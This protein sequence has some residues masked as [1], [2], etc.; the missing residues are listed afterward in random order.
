L[1][2]AAGN[3]AA[4]IAVQPL[5]NFHG[6]GHLNHSLFWENLSPASKDGGAPPTGELAKAIDE[7]FGGVDAF[8]TKMN[9]ALAGIQG[10]GWGWL[11]KDK[12]SGKLEL[13]TKPVC[14]DRT[15]HIK[16]CCELIEYLRIKIL[17]WVNMSHCWESM[18][19]NMRTSKLN[20]Y[21]Q[22]YQMWR[23]SNKNFT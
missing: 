8:K 9:A 6:G 22:P 18:L 14:I 16:C 21:Q 13:I 17:L 5:L 4:A 19:G 20:F 7:T 11:V 12:D 2:A 10:S 23:C 1:S 3:P 15:F